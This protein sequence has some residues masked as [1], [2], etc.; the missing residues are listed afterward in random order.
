MGAGL[1]I[2]ITL[3]SIIGGTIACVFI[4]MQIVDYFHSRTR[5]KYN[6]DK[7]IERVEKCPKLTAKQFI[8]FVSVCPEK[9]RWP[10]YE[11]MFG[12]IYVDPPILEDFGRVW[13]TNANEMY[14][15]CV[16]YTQ[17]RKK[18]ATMRSSTQE[19]I[20]MA[21]FIERMNKEISLA[22]ESANQMMNNSEQQLRDILERIEKNKVQGGH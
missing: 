19:A 20:A 14:K 3:T 17:F 12:S 4:G 22:Q 7:N 2:F 21:K 5:K 16:W 11:S 6:W 10:D 1:I 18:E 9:W 8:K 13:F 15:A